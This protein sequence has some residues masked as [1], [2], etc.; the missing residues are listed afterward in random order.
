MEITIELLRESGAR[1]PKAI[2]QTIGIVGGYSNRGM[3]RLGQGITRPVYGTTSSH[4]RYYLL[5]D[6]NL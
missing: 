1:L 5:C 2:G 4:S 6:T 3:L